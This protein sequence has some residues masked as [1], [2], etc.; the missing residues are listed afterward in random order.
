MFNLLDSLHIKIE[1]LK[2]PISA[3]VD[4]P[5]HHMSSIRSYFQASVGN[6]RVRGTIVHCCIVV[7]DVGEDELACET[8]NSAQWMLYG[9][10]DHI[11][12]A[13]R[14]GLENYC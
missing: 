8:P 4:V 7:C 6:R 3:R 1:L 10:L 14:D 13:C 2:T 5:I 11:D 9:D 12:W